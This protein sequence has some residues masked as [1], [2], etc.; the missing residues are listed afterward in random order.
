MGYF[1]EEKIN[2]EGFS[3]ASLIFIAF[4][5]SRLL[6]KILSLFFGVKGVF[7]TMAILAL[8]YIIGI[9]IKIK[10]KEFTFLQFFIAFFGLLFLTALTYYFNRDI[11]F[12]LAE[13]E[14]GFAIKVFNVRDSISALLVILLIHDMG[15]ISRALRIV[16]YINAIYFLVQIYL[17]YKVGNWSNYFVTAE[18]KAGTYNMNLGYDL[19]F[20]GFILLASFLKE[21]KRIVS[22]LLSIV[23]IAYAIVFG[24]R[25]VLI[26]VAGFFFCYLVFFFNELKE[27][28]RYK[29]LIAL[30]VVVAAL[31]I[32]LPKVNEYFL[33]LNI[34]K[35]ESMS[36]EEKLEYEEKFGEIDEQALEV[37]D[38]SRTLEMI[39]GGNFLE[40]NGRTYIWKRG[41]E[42]FMNSP[43][44]GNGIFGDRPYVGQR[45]QWGYSH[46]II[47]ELASNFG[48]IGLGLGTIMLGLIIYTFVKKDRDT[49]Y[50]FLVFSALMA[51]LLLSDS[52]Y[53]VYIFWSMVGLLLLTYFDRPEKYRLK[54][55]SALALL[56]ATVVTVGFATKRDYDDQ[57]FD[58]VEFEKP[59]TIIAITDYDRKYY[60]QIL[61]ILANN[62]IKA[63]FFKDS[64][65]LDIKDLIKTGL[66]VQDYEK[67]T[68]SY[69][70]A[71]NEIIEE[72]LKKSEDLYESLG[73]E[74]AKAYI[75][76]FYSYTAATRYFLSDYRTF[77]LDNAYD[78]TSYKNINESNRLYLLANQ[79]IVAKSPKVAYDMTEEDFEERQKLK[80][81]TEVLMQDTFN[82]ALEKNRLVIVDFKITDD[83]NF[84]LFKKAIEIVKLNQIET[85]NFNDI[86]EESKVIEEDVDLIDNLKKNSGITNFISN[87]LD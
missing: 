77:L 61:E 11:G 44:Y 81:E 10:N 45:Y 70:V 5:T 66:D 78:I 18:A 71:D 1:M 52:I 8:L 73:K 50:I 75:T 83:I 38:E 56:L 62:N 85:Y 27:K 25:G 46:N 54:A 36:T 76:P 67:N 16:G 55:F 87:F 59:S 69:K 35:F 12:W 58:A 3:F 31:T 65:D 4:F 79:I 34:E 63:S 19:A 53:F 84:D 26:L 2:K 51:K 22:Y 60:N 80:D 37:G 6:T 86:Y 41:I 9:G 57:K 14:F 28:N 68:P 49:K 23:T 24:S 40:S 47:I 13:R 7:M 15:K 30:V 64:D 42:A 17:F 29:Y 48:A 74:K 33:N 32:L 82:E 39:K 21:P 20:C 72:D 43:I